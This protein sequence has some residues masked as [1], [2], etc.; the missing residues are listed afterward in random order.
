MAGRFIM[1]KQFGCLFFL[2]TRPMGITRDC[3]LRGYVREQGQNSLIYDPN[4]APRD[5]A[6]WSGRV[7]REGYAT[8]VGVLVWF[9]NGVKVSAYQGNIIRGTWTTMQ[10]VDIGQSSNSAGSEYVPGN[11][12]PAQNWKSRNSSPERTPPTP[13]LRREESTEGR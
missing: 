5:V 1:K 6:Y 2:D 8:G 11:N 3:P 10:E 9:E 7:D 13:G 4:P 12:T